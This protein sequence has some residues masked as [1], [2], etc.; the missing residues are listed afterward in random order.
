MSNTYGILDKKKMR[1]LYEIRVY[2]QTENLRNENIMGRIKRNQNDISDYAELLNEEENI[3][4]KKKTKK[5]SSKENEGENE[6]FENKLSDTSTKI[7]SDVNKIISNM[8]Q[9][10][11]ELK[12]LNALFLI[13]TSKKVNKTNL[14]SLNLPKLNNQSLSQEKRDEK[15]IEEDEKNKKNNKKSKPI[16][17]TYINDNY[18]KQLNRAFMNFNPIIHLGN[19]NLLRKAD[20]SINEDIQK[21]EKHI[22]DDLKT[23][24]DPYYYK[25]Q[26]EKLLKEHEKLKKRINTAPTLQTDNYNSNNNNYNNNYNNY[27]NNYNPNTTFRRRRK[28]KLEIKRKFPDKELRIKEL[29]NMNDCLIQ[30]SKSINND[31]INHYYND[32]EILKNYSIEQQAHNY[33]PDIKKANDIMREIQQDKLIRGLNQDTKLKKKYVDGENN[34]IVDQITRSKDL[35]LKEIAEV[36]KK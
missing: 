9:S 12:K 22:D 33:F 24:I 36:E 13:E 19:L 3:K 29:K 21:L 11:E 15:L 20:P 31:N 10:T 23:I 14:Q 34:R 7:I 5:T 32:Y 4:K 28:N 26:Y 6:K 27:N 8:N 30:I 17:F 25:H 1:K 16:N 35:L 18:R 2:T